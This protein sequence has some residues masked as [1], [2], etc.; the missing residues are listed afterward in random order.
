M[1]ATC[2]ATPAAARSPVERDLYAAG[3]E[4]RVPITSTLNASLATRYDY[5]DDITAVGGAST[6][7]LGLEW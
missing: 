4:F 2:S 7:N 1:R 5:Y 3:V 6:Y